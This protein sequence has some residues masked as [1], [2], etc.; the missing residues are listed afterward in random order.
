MRIILLKQSRLFLHWCSFILCPLAISNKRL[1]PSDPK[2]PA[3]KF[4]IFIQEK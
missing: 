3:S 2:T 4:N 1:T